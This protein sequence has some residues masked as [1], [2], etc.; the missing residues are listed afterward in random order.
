MRAANFCKNSDKYWNELQDD[1]F[2]Y[3]PR[4]FERTYRICQDP[5]SNFLKPM[6]F[7]PFS[8]IY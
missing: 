4:I 7:L 5:N 8:A 2:H 1:I 3:I 6:H